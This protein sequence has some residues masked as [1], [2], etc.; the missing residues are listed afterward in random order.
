MRVHDEAVY[1]TETGHAVRLYAYV[2]RRVWVC[3][4]RERGACVCVCEE[5]WSRDY[6]KG[7][8]RV[9][10]YRAARKAREKEKARNHD[11]CIVNALM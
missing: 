2:H 5:G 11:P 7:E 1:A 4:C 6:R 3:V 9:C 8:S 10:V